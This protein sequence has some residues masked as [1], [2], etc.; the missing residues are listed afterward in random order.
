MSG[1]QKEYKTSQRRVCRSLGWQRSVIRYRGRTSAE[2]ETLQ[3]RLSAL[4]QERISWGYRRLHQLLLR[5]GYTVS[6]SAVYRLYRRGGLMVRRKKRSKRKVPGIGAAS[7]PRPTRLNQV[8]TMDF[9]EDRLGSGRKFRIFDLEDQFSRECLSLEVEF[10]LNSEHVLA[11]L[12]QLRQQRPLPE[13]IVVDNGSEFASG[14]VMG[15]AERHGV[16]L[17]FI[18]PGRPTQNAFIESFHSRLRQ[19]CLDLHEFESIEE[20]REVIEAWRQD[21][22]Q[23]RPH[24][25]LG[26][27]TPTEKAAVALS[28][29]TVTPGL[30]SPTAPSA[31]ALQLV[32]Q[33]VQESTGPS[34]P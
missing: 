9:T 20:A 2:R 33:A 25:G 17:H 31:P 8:W 1:L 29:P 18:Q 13:R 4:A 7:P 21:Y 11:A 27:L 16:K 12:E 23:A 6:R 30:R 10:R 32:E 5:E 28:V 34:V 24:S 3:A 14:V 15:W 22:N 19:E 26:W